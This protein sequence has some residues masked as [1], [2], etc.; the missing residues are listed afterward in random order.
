MLQQTSAHR[1]ALQHSATHKEHSATMGIT[2]VELLLY[3]L[4]TKVLGR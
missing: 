4:G 2:S 3:Q 1:N